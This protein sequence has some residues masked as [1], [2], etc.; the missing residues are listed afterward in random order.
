MKP[1]NLLIFKDYQV[2][3]GDFGC[4]L[5]LTNDDNSEYYISGLTNFYSS[6]KALKAFNNNE[7]LNKQELF[8][9]D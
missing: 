2:K 8:T 7:A 5:K 4:S 3:L 6:A 9:N 1:E